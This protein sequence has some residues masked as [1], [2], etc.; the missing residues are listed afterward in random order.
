[1]SIKINYGSLETCAG[2]VGD[3]KFV[4]LSVC[5]ETLKHLNISERVDVYLAVYCRSSLTTNKVTASHTS[6][7]HGTTSSAN[8]EDRGKPAL[9]LHAK[10][11]RPLV[12][13]EKRLKNLQPTEKIGVKV[14]PNVSTTRDDISISLSKSHIVS[15]QFSKCRIG[16]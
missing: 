7:D 15:F 9:I 5:L 13:P 12:W 6:M 10:T 1:M 11:W 2:A 8:Q 4:C 3:N 16:I 14:W